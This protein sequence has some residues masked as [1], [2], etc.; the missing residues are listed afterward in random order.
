[1]PYLLAQGEGPDEHWRYSLE[2]GRD[3]LIGRV[4]GWSCSWDKM[5][6]RRHAHIKLVG[7]KGER[8]RVERCEEA[9]NPIFFRGQE[10]DRFE[11]RSGEYF[12]IGSTR[13]SFVESLA[14]WDEQTQPLAERQF[15]SKALRDIPFTDAT[16]RLAV[17]S[18]LPELLD[19]VTHRP[20][21]LR[22]LTNVLLAGV[23]VA[24]EVA[25]LKAPSSLLR[26]SVPV[27]LHSDRRV[28][29]DRVLRPSRRLI[30]Q[31]VRSRETVLQVWNGVSQIESSF[32]AQPHT[33]WAMA[34]W[35]QGDSEGD[36]ILY[37]AGESLPHDSANLSK[38]R[39]I[40]SPEAATEVL[41]PE[42]RFVDLVSTI[43]SRTLQLQRLER[44]Q[45]SLRQF[46]PSNLQELLHAPDF[47]QSL[48][49]R[50]CETAV[51]F[52]DLRGFSQKSEEQAND[53]M[54]LLARVSQVLSIT[55]R[56]ILR[57]QGVIGDFHGDST[58]GFW[59]WPLDDEQRIESACRAALAIRRE[60]LERASDPT[61][62]LSGFELGLGI[63]SGKAVVGRI[64]TADHVK[65][66]AFGP[67]VNLASRLESLTRSLRASILIDEPT[68]MVVRQSLRGEARVR[69]VGVVLPAGLLE[70]VTVYELLP[71]QDTAGSLSDEAIAAYERAWE[72]VAARD[73]QTAVQWLHQVPAD[74]RVKD[75]LTVLIAQHDRKCP[76]HWPGY[77]TIDSK[78][79]R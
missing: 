49:P 73:W 45:S 18:E 3:E 77:L 1:M 53:L 24:D 26:H 47:D 44:T 46:F 22:R 8:L 56:Q 38:Q 7:S 32:T 40:I 64:G 63:A 28:L 39:T 13:F 2:S 31:V 58:M 9:R 11:L 19:H 12:V 70:P 55:T 62:S 6:S 51:L 15:T 10:E 30:E 37:L 74:D 72:A 78:L 66:T 17:L 23:S 65:V 34:S 68:A 71:S 52:C 41:Q 43:V 29:R 14:L 5:L 60:L 79:V 16:R 27:V 36:W 67:V 35:V 25:I 33:A 59:G 76:Q 57:S 48:S 4:E 54:G 50:E 61:D 75:C 69:K 42:L 20:E 21:M